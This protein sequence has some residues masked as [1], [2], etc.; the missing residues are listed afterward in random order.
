MKKLTFVVLAMLVS[1]S[2]S[3]SNSHSASFS[4]SS[5]SGAA[6][7]GHYSQ[8]VSQSEDDK[9]WYLRVSIQGYKPEE[10]SIRLMGR[11]LQLE[12]RHTVGGSVLNQFQQSVSVPQGVFLDT[13]ESQWDPKGELL[14]SGSKVQNQKAD[15]PRAI[16]IKVSQINSTRRT[17]NV[18]S[19]NIDGVGYISIGDINSIG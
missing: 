9:S 11:N 7:S 3:N 5:S 15:K 13:I 10:L 12:G 14:I 16:D 18:V 2:T 8:S 6:S 17:H 1:V 19:P 4:S